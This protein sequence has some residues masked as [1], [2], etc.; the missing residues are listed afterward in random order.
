VYSVQGEVTVPDSVSLPAFVIVKLN[1]ALWPT[2]TVPKLSED[3][4]T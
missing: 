4:D 3:A 2:M 1:S